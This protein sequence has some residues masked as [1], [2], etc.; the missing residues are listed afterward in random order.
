MENEKLKF[1]LD[2]SKIFERILFNLHMAKSNY[3]YKKR[4]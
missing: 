4:S 3:K 1:L 2:Y